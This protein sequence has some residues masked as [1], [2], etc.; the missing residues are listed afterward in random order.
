MTA[1]SV[2][3]RRG[4]RTGSGR[5]Y[6]IRPTSREDAP[7]LVT[8][9][10][11]VAAEGDVI[12][13]VPGERSVFEE[14][15]SLSTVLSQGGLALTLVVDGEVSGQLLVTRRQGRYQS[16]IGDLAILV[17]KPCRGLGLGRRLMETA[18]DWGRAVRLEKLSLGVFSS[19]ERAISLYRAV[20][21][22][23]E[24]LRRHQIMLPSGP[25]DLMLMGLRLSGEG[26]GS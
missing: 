23:D 2:L 15:L 25:R 1:P 13:A 14:E 7:A 6:A 4:G 20:G 21:F 18:V 26:P 22:V 16:H 9:R 17:S 12:A 19:N 5:E 11:L 10:D 8:L 24:G 3:L